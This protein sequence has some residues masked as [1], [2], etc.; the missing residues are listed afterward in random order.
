MS[1][2][3]SV[4]HGM[5]TTNFQ[6]DLC[7]VKCFPTVW[8]TAQTFSALAFNIAREVTIIVAELCV[9]RDVLTSEKGDPVIEQRLLKTY[10]KGTVDYNNSY[11]NIPGHT[12]I[13]AI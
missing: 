6:H 11:T 9:G 8:C 7:S 13:L 10:W 5:C 2:L 12:N 3:E 4:S 1:T